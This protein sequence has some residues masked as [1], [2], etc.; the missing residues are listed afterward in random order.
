VWCSDGEDFELNESIEN[1]DCG[2]NE[3]KGEEKG[4]E[5]GRETIGTVSIKVVGLWSVVSGR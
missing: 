4:R 3:E 5:G 2:W 1:V